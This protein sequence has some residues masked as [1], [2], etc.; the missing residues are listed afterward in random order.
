MRTQAVGLIVVK[1]GPNGLTIIVSESRA[2]DVAQGS[3]SAT[4]MDI[5]P[6]RTFPQDCGELM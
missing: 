4:H 3:R 2:P 6:S 1:S 5:V